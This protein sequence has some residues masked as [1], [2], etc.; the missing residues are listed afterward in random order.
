MELVL[1]REQVPRDVAERELVPELEPDGA[2][3]P[4]PALGDVAQPVC[5]SQRVHRQ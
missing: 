5:A 1:K 3:V 4:G 2:V